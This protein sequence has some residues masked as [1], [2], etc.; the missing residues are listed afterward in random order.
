MGLVVLEGLF[1]LAL[2]LTGFREAV[3][4]AIPKHLKAAIAIG[5][6]LFIAFI[7]LVDS[8]FVRPGAGT[9]VTLGANG[10]LIGWPAAVFAFGLF[11]IAILYNRKVKG[12]ILIGI[13]CATV[14]AIIVESI[15]N[16]GAQKDATGKLVNP[17]GWALNVPS[18]PDKVFSVPHFDTVGHVSLTGA[19]SSDAVLAVLL[20]FVLFQT[21][22][23]DTMGTMTAIGK[24][25]GLNDAN[26]N[27][28]RT[29]AILAVDS[30][31]AAAGGFGGV[32]S[33]TSYIESASGVGEG[34][35]TG[36]S[37][38][39]VGALF[40]VATFFSPL[41]EIVPFEAAT[42]ALVFVGYLMVKQGV[43]EIDWRNLEEGLPAFA[44]AILMPFTYSI[45]VGVGAGFIF[46]V[47]LKATSG[48]GRDIH[49]LMWVVSVL[50]AL[51][52]LLDPLKDLLGVG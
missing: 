29:R 20:I 22:F 23:F 3:L 12:A 26:G 4:Y 8:G 31:G 38:V 40:A 41:V 37:T 21:D 10:E 51:Y 35:R 45:S 14:L 1:T 52:F 33:N 2:V 50:F 5:I 49:P 39:V 19:F 28:P 16:I 11:L 48:K 36:L 7:G 6:G 25:A 30:I 46:H 32:S 27:P 17:A 47:V 18:W 9:P 44:T 34:A 24:E 15:G 13:A 42:P 43:D